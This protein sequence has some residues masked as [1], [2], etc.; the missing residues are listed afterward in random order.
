MGKKE[1]RWGRF[2]G[3]FVISK[4]DWVIVDYQNSHHRDFQE[5]DPDSVEDCL[6]LVKVRVKKRLAEAN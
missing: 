1:R 2:T 5:I 3:S 6:E 4:G